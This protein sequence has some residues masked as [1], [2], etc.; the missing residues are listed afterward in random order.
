MVKKLLFTL[1]FCGTFS[2]FSQNLYNDSNA[3]SPTNESNAITGWTN[4]AF[5]TSDNSDS[6][7]GLFSLRAE[8]TG[9]NGSVITYE[10]DAVIGQDY[11]ISIWAREGAQ[12]NSPAFA[13]WQGLN[14]FSTTGIAGNTWTEYVFNVTATSINP[15]IRVYTSPWSARLVA[16]NT[17]FIDNISIV[18]A[19]GDTE[20]P[21]A[22]SDLSSS[23]T[24]STSTDLSWSDPGDNVGVTDYEV[25]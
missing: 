11:V 1:L 2:A 17:V 6:Q 3:A 22:V 5:L 21:N 18:A 12:S 7:S 10:F 20:S 23:N 15:T 16:G 13:N 14:G 9:N 24:T 19:G 25:F 4:Q 8:S